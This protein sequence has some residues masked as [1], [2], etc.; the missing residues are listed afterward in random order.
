MDTNTTFIYDPEDPNSIAAQINEQAFYNSVI[1]NEM[2]PYVN[3]HR[4]WNEPLTACTSNGVDKES[5]P[6]VDVFS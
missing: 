2:N 1:S 5:I 4:W 6:C 3:T